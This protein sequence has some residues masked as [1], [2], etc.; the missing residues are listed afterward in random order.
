MCVAPP[1]ALEGKLININLGF[2]LFSLPLFLCERPP[3]EIL[4]RKSLLKT[5]YETFNIQF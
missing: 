3:K 1:I 2:V 4:H 5:F